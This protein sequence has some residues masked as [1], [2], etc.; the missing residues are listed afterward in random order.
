MGN[1][2]ATAGGG[3][4]SW[5]HCSAGKPLDARDLNRDAASCSRFDIKRGLTGEFTFDAVCSKG[6]Y[7]GVT[8]AVVTG[9][10]NSTYVWDVATTV[11]LP[12][13]PPMVVKSHSEARYLGPC[14]AGMT[15]EG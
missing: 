2:L 7:S 4:D 3:P 15:P 10:F 11:N 9:D 1:H 12:G 14:P 5:R 8:H 13:R 6:G